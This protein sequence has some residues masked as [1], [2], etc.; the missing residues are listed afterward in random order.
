MFHA[1]SQQR[2]GAGENL[3]GA[4]SNVGDT[5]ASGAHMWYKEIRTYNYNNPQWA[6]HGHF[7]AMVW[8]DTKKIGCGEAGGYVTC[9]Y[10]P[11]GNMNVFSPNSLRNHVKPLK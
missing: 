1:T 6:R 10:F 3:Y 4:P 9:R 5:S 7:T 2:Q 8:T 11:Q